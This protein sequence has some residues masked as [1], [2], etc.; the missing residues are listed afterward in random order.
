MPGGTSE[1]DQVADVGPMPRS[2]RLVFN[3]DGT[4]RELVQ[5]GYRKFGPFVFGA[6]QPWKEPKAD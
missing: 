2:A 6:Y 3:R 5:M 1:I 4:P